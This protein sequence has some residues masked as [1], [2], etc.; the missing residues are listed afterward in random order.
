MCK[1]CRKQN[2]D[3]NREIKLVQ[4]KKYDSENRENLKF[5]LFIQT[6]MMKL[7]ANT[8][9]TEEERLNIWKT[10]EKQIRFLY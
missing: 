4:Q 10:D 1:S 6:T 7:K 9:I 2:V 3:E 8:L 5:Y